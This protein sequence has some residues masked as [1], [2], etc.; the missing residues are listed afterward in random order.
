MARAEAERLLRLGRA[1]RDRR[2]ARGLTR[3]RLAVTT[4]LDLGAVT[5]IEAGEADPPFTVLLR[6]AR[7]LDTTAADLLDAA[8]DP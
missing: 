6:L 4:G 5:A 1:V 7:A 8:Q 2:E 3:E